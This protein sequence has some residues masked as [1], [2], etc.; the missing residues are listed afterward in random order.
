M[1]NLLHKLFSKK[2]NQQ[3]EANLF[4]LLPS[5]H[6]SSTQVHT[7]LGHQFVNMFVVN[8]T[9]FYHQ[10]GFQLNHYIHNDGTLTRDDYRYLM[11]HFPHLII[12]SRENVFAA[13]PKQL[14][15]ISIFMSRFAFLHISTTDKI[16]FMDCDVVFFS[17]PKLI[18]RWILS[19][20]NHTSYYLKDCANYYTLSPIEIH[21]ISS[22]QNII[23]ALSDGLLCV[24]TPNFQKVFSKNLTTLIK[25]KNQFI[26]ERV[27]GGF[28]DNTLWYLGQ[29]LWAMLFGSTNSRVLPNNHL[30]YARHIWN[31]I[32]ISTSLVCIHYSGPFKQEMLQLHHK[33]WTSGLRVD[34]LPQVLQSNRV[35]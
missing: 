17:Q 30:V 28:G 8:T 26:K 24:Y 35:K 27:L 11:K 29:T 18:S 16:I 6:I 15:N 14:R 32:E 21:S 25:G 19:E 2:M 1:K 3:M 13:T 31:K 4:A 7:I 12:L 22:Q 10:L 20:T 34:Q 9:L 33:L 23:P 5:D